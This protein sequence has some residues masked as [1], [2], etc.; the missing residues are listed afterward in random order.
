MLFGVTGP[1]SAHTK[2]VLLPNGLCCEPRKFTKL[3]KPLISTLRLDGH[4]GIYIDDLINVGLTFDECVENV[5]T[6]IKLLNSLGFIIHLDKS[7]FLPKQEITFLGFSINSLK[8][9]ITLTDTKKETLKAC[10]IELLHKNNQTIG[11]VA[12]VIGLMASSLPRVKG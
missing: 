7:I 9:E 6:S 11:Y 8:I 4:T 12:K 10:C 1:L 2:F 5:I 3:M